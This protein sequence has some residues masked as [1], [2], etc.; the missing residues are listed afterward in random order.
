MKTDTDGISI[1]NRYLEAK[2]RHSGAWTYALVARDVETLWL[3]TCNGQWFS[4]D[5]A[6]LKTKWDSAQ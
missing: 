4:W 6:T 1:A 3:W 2:A 5:E